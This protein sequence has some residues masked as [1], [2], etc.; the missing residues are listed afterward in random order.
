MINYPPSR[1]EA[2]P[3]IFPKKTPDAPFILGYRPDNPPNLLMLVGKMAT[4]KTT[5]SRSLTKEGYE[6]VSSS[7]CIAE[8]IGFEP[9]PL[10][11]LQFMKEAQSLLDSKD[12][13]KTLADTFS[14]RILEIHKIRENAK[15]IIDGVRHVRTTQRLQQAF[16]NL[17]ILYIQTPIALANRNYLKRNGVLNPAGEDQGDIHDRLGQFRA[18]RSFSTERDIPSIGRLANARVANRGNEEDFHTLVK[19]WL[20]IGPGTHHSE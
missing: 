20:K 5:L 12:G 15:L 7:G 17:Y 1:P 14:R 19:D 10:N 9:N 3:L 2:S 4:G 6:V 8:I 18:E 13:F 16:S 11:K